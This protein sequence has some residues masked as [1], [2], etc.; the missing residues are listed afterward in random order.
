[1]E[2]IMD[3]EWEDAQVVRTTGIKV[4]ASK[5]TARIEVEVR[6]WEG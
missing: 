5:D 3:S 6:P 2:T 1:M 4:A